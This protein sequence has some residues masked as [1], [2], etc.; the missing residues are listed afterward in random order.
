MRLPLNSLIYD[1]PDDILKSK[2]AGDFSGAL[3]K[4]DARLKKENITPMLRDR[5]TVEKGLIER[6][7]IRYPYTRE[8]A[9]E[10]AN[11]RISNFTYEEFDAF[12]D[13]GDIDFI[14]VNGEKKYLSSCIGA[15]IK[16]HPHLHARQV[17]EEDRIKDPTDKIARTE[18]REKGELAYKFT[19]KRSIQVKDKCFIPNT[20][21]TAHLPIPAAAAQQDAAKIEI[22]ADADAFIPPVDEYQR[23]VCYKRF[24]SENKPFE[25][26]YTFENRVKFVDPFKD[27]PHIVYP[28]AIAPCAD[29]LSEQ[30][31]QI[32]FTPYL[33]E[34]A[35]LIA[36]DETRPLYL[37]KRVYDY[38]TQ[39]VRY[40]FMRSYILVENHPEFTAINQKGDCGMQAILFITLCRILGIPARWQSGRTVEKD[41]SGCHDWAQFYTEEFGWL[42]ADPSYGGGGWRNG[43]LECWNFYFGNLDPFRMIAN[44]R[45]YTPFNPPKKHEYYDPY[46]SQDGEIECE[47]RGFDTYD[48][49][50]DGEV[51]EYVKVED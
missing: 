15:L 2:L 12:E 48:F 23:A 26:T 4:I 7:E 35:K 40:S 14:Y 13:A 5:L 18:M 50:D 21:Y 6:L 10:Y 33:K 30:V 42:F 28:S 51:L 20:V 46:D 31:P 16:M 34:L 49:I 41:D 29:D 45:Y 43:D 47:E 27:T 19:M 37:A 25:V 3:R 32:T 22:K 1:L 17:K 9:V 11:T 24:L 39:N 38:V 36:G 44:R 8:Q